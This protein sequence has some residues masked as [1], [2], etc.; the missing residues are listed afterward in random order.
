M[1]TGLDKPTALPVLHPADEAAR[2]LI[3]GS[4]PHVRFAV[5][6]L[7][8]LPWIGSLLSASAALHAER[9][10]QEVNLVVQRWLDEHE[11]RLVALRASLASVADR[12]DAL[13]EGAVARLNHEAFLPL[14]R[15]AYQGWDRAQHK[16]K[17]QLFER[18]LVSAAGLDGDG[19][20]GDRVRLFVDWI[21]RYDAAHFRIVSALN[22]RPGLTRLG[23]WRATGRD[24]ALPRED[25]SEADL[26]RM[27][28]HDLSAG[29]VMRQ[30]RRTDAHGRFLRTARG[31]A[32]GPFLASSFDDRA[33]YE[34][35]ELGRD[36]VRF[37]LEPGPTLRIPSDP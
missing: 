32:I 7:G 21:D 31:R 14:V 4:S 30:V 28:V 16:A 18:L 33:P 22:A 6:A 11:A 19:W 9:Q 23:I 2:L 15:R 10:Q 27:L 29:R 13:G 26:Y 20:Q 34:L 1:S 12:V 37:V 36:F 25:S 24:G 35:S 5:A 3:P 8:V 17:R